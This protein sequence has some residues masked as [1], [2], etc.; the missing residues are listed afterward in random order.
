M[1]DNP[2]TN[3]PFTHQVLGH[4]TSNPF[5]PLDYWGRNVGELK[6]RS[7]TGGIGQIVVNVH[8][9][10]S[11]PQKY[12]TTINVSEPPPYVDFFGLQY[13]I[14][15]DSKCSN[16]WDSAIMTKILLKMLLS[17]ILPSPFLFFRV[18]NFHFPY[19]LIV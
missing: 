14:K 11:Q 15:V 7:N 2:T 1:W 9:S 13:C 3:H 12:L 19:C 16:M 10:L 18:G 5:L 17:K 4:R 6:W 8:L